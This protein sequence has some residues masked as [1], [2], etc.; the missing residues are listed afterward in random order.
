MDIEEIEKIFNTGERQQIEMMARN[1]LVHGRT[2]EYM[3]SLSLYSE[4][5]SHL[6][7]QTN[8]GDKEYLTLVYILSEHL[9]ELSSGACAC[10]IVD[11]PMFNSPDRLTGIL[12]ILEEKLDPK[13]Y[14]IWNHSRCL[15]CGNEYE[16][17]CV[18]SGFG[19]KVLWNKYS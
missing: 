6:L 9:N 3:K 11:K 1:I 16:S 12:E 17:K 19:Q 14:S 18:E 5:F 13:E 10:S 2:H 4:R 8:S 7:S 15:S